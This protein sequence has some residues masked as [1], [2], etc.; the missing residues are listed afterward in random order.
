MCR[1]AM[2]TQTQ[3]RLMD[4]VGEG[5]GG[6]NREEHW[7]TSPH[8]NRSPAGICYSS[9]GARVGADNL[10]GGMVSGS[11]GRFKREGAYVYLCVDVWQKPAQYHEA[12]ILQLQINKP[13]KTRETNHK[14]RITWRDLPLKKMKS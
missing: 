11:G 13:K 7:N 6:A 1:V 2:E 4:T 8:E 3:N 9:L 5:E 12:I 10:G 14:K